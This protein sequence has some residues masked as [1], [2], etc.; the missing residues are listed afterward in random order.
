MTVN[1]ICDRKGL[2]WVL[3]EL[4]RAKG[5][6]PRPRPWQIEP[7]TFLYVR[8]PARTLSS[9]NCLTFQSLSSNLAFR[10]YLQICLQVLPQS[11]PDLERRA[12]QAERGEDLFHSVPKCRGQ[13]EARLVIGKHGIL[14]T[15]EARDPGRQMLA[16]VS[17]RHAA[18]AGMT[19]S[20]ICDWYLEEARWST[21]RSQ[22][23]GD[24]TLDTRFG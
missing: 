22:P 17:K 19:V 24:P 7:D 18:R 12:G 2:N 5:S 23:P 1:V 10:S 15:D 4:E 13:D 8:P 6:N 16:E 3:R 21:G 20:E 9:H 11:F 14:A